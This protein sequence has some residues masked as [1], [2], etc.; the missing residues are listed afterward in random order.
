M[1]HLTGRLILVCS[2]SLSL[3]LFGAFAARVLSASCRCRPG[4]LHA[5]C[6][7]QTGNLAD[8]YMRGQRTSELA[9]LCVCFTRQAD[10]QTGRQADR[11]A[12]RQT[13]PSRHPSIHRLRSLMYTRHSRRWICGCVGQPADH[14]HTQT[15]RQ[16][17]RRKKSHVCS[18]AGRRKQ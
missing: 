18:Q 15:D 8:H 11:Q 5:F 3:S 1:I 6:K 16:S 14:T 17:D 12:N 7:R 9:D 13:D 4:G 2:L 10:R